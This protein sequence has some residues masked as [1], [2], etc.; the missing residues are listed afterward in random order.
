MIQAR[1]EWAD[2]LLFF[3]LVKSFMSGLPQTRIDESPVQLTVGVHTP[4][5]FVGVGERESEREK[6][7]YV[8]VCVW[9]H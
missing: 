7:R 6:E 3:R 2:L 4:S 5:V 1:P 9:I 8:C